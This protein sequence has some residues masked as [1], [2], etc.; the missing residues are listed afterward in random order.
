MTI[1]KLIKQN[2]H[3]HALLLVIITIILSPP[4]NLRETFTFI[5]DANDYQYYDV[6]S[7]QISELRSLDYPEITHDKKMEVRI[8]VP[9]LLRLVFPFDTEYLPIFIYFLNLL[10]LYL[11][12]FQLIKFQKI[13]LPAIKPHFLLAFLFSTIYTGIC[14]AMDFS[15]YFDGIAFMLI[16][17]A[18]NQNR[19]LFKVIFM[20]AALFVD[21]RSILASAMILIVSMEKSVVRSFLGFVGL[22]LVYISLR[23]ALTKFYGLNSLFHKSSDLEFFK[24]IHKDNFQYLTISFMNCFKSLWILPLLIIYKYQKIPYAARIVQIPLLVILFAGILF[25]AVC[26]LDFTRSF[27]YGYP[28][29]IY[30]VYYL[31]KSG[32]DVRQLRLILT[33]IGISNLF[34]ETHY[35]N[36]GDKIYYTINIFSK[37]GAHL[38]K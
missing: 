21:E 23:V 26:V 7:E 11:F 16:S 37:I 29:F 6:V 25:G 28:F 33:I 20:L 18:L 19:F 3:L 31:Y 10:A 13:H 24:Y 17:F 27:S 1:P 22:I 2:D 14:F 5:I 32:I 38:L 9:L 36:S 4:S 8:F 34:A 30:L 12:Y 35:F 15:P